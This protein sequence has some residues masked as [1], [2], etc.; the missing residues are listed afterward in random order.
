MKLKLFTVLT[1]G[2]FVLSGMNLHAQATA[3]EATDQQTDQADQQQDNLTPEQKAQ[4]ADPVLQANLRDSAI[5]ADKW[6]KLLD[7]GD[8]G[9][10]WDAGAVTFK[11]TISKSEWTKAMQKL[12]QPLGSVQSRTLLEQRTA[13][14]PKGLPAG[15]YMVL[16]YKTAFAN[17]PNGNELVTMVQE[18]DGS[19]RVLTYQGR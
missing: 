18:S 8:Y 13:E 16:F 11:F 19:W 15:H 9:S 3:T 14:N 7:N 10:S 2:L 1:M 5:A 17:R 12:R 6:L 4:L